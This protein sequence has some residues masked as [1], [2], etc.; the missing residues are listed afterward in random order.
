MFK[1]LYIFS[2]KVYDRMSKARK[3]SKG[4]KRAPGAYILFTQDHRNNVKNALGADAKSTDIQ[5]E[6]GRRW[7]VLPDSEKEKYKARSLSLQAKM[8]ASA[9]SVSSSS[10]A[11]KVEESEVSSQSE[12]DD[13]PPVKRAKT[14][15]RK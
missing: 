14:D 4:E 10:K 7:K 8:D 1:E 12:S 13:A 3:N 9:S 11:A 5:K 15:K 2:K 6:L